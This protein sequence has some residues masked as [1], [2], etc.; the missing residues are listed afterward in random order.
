MK[1]KIKGLIYFFT[2]AGILI[3]GTLIVF[4][5]QSE[6]IAIRLSDYITSRFGQER[7]L[8]IEVGNIGGS[9]LR[10]IRLEDLCISYTG[11]EAPRVLLSAAEVYGKF[12]LASILIGKVTFDSIGVKSARLILPRRSD[13]SFIL[14]TG[15]AP[16]QPGGKRSRLEIKK[17]ALA[18]VSVVVEGGEPKVFTDVD[19]V[20]SYVQDAG[21]ST[22]NLEC[23]SF[24][25]GKAAQIDRITGTARITDR[26]I[27]ITDAVVQSPGSR[28][29]FSGSIGIDDND[30]LRVEAI[31]DSLDIG[32]AALFYRQGQKSDMGSIAGHIDAQGRY[33]DLS[34][35]L[36]LEGAA[37]DW[38]FEDLLA[39]AWYGGKEIRIN[40]LT[41]VL[42]KTPVD[43]SGE[44]TFSAPPEYEGVIAFANLDL[45]EFIRDSS[46]DYSSD[47]SGSVRFRGEGVDAEHFALETWPRLASGRYL[48]W[49]FDSVEGKVSLDAESVT[50]DGVRAGIGEARLKTD[51]A[52]GFDGELDLGFVLSCPDLGDIASYHKLEDLVGSITGTGRVVHKDGVFG[53]LLLSTGKQIE[54]GGTV[55]DSLVLDLDLTRAESG[56]RG[57]SQIFASSLDIH[58]FKATEFIGDVSVEDSRIAIERAVFIRENEDLLGAVGVVDLVDGGFDLGV[59]NL[60]VELGGF[61][62]ENADTILASYRQD[63][64]SVGDF[65]ISSGMGRVSIFNSSYVKGKYTVESRLDDFDL[66]LLE[67]VVRAEIP[68]G[69]L[70]LDLKASGTSDS[71]AFEVDFGV[72]DGEFRSVPFETLSGALSYNGRALSI[73]RISLAQNGGN[74]IVEGMVPMNLAPSR[75][76]ELAKAGRAYD[77]ID[78]LGQVTIQATDIDISLIET[79]LPPLAKLKGY[80]DLSMEISGSKSNPLVVSTGRL[81][82]AN[83]H[84]TR[85]GEISWNLNLKDSLLTISEFTF[86]DGR[87]TGSISGQVPIAISI[88]PFRSQLLKRPI[89]VAVSVEGGDVGLMCSLFPQLR[90]CSGRYDVDLGITGTVDDPRFRGR[91]SLSRARLR[92]A[93]VAQDVRDLFIDV[94]LEGKRFEITRL[95][96]EEGAVTGIGFLR[97]EGTRIVEW[98]IDLAFKDYA[99]TEFEDFYARIEGNLTI[100]TE[101]FESG[102]PIPRIEGSL[103]VKEGEYFYSLI[104]GGG[105]GEIIA[106]SASPG[107]IMNVAIEVP[108]DFWIRGDDIEAELQGDLSVKRGKEGL[109]V[110]GSLRTLRGRFYV[111]H[112]SFRI[113]RGE[114]RFSDVTSLKNAYIDLEAESRVL[115]EKITLLAKGYIDRLDISA[116]SESG[117]SET[118]IFEALTLRRGTPSDEAEQKGFFSSEFIRSWGL[119]LVNRF[120]NDVAR[121][122]NLDQFG[123][124]VGDLGEGDALATTR[125]IFGKYVSDKVYLEYTQAL[126]SLYGDRTRFT[127]RGLSFPER[128]LSVEY[129]L[130]N[131]FSIEGETGTVGGLGY[132]DVD[133]KFT[134]GY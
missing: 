98:D 67:D 48:E 124:E 40:R 94:E 46:E 62:W 132:F 113:T 26:V 36:D 70:G 102:K 134:F 30:S 35:R 23:C 7:N 115:D 120:G 77:I 54:Y 110:L 116:T 111:Y 47:L 81:R 45:S 4:R 39:D 123:V 109:L 112:N 104:G 105:E 126:G 73:G 128:Q 106:P 13:G 91:I 131:R 75:V 59:E 78:D 125:L 103:K 101:I 92:L 56:L 90:V 122:L 71:L 5:T 127:Q 79:L 1:R 31:I 53:V 51:G 8:S 97:L 57:R 76:S 20:G 74:V 88:L 61:I 58:G 19:M 83:Y 49:G 18:E 68:T 86:G 11:G 85:I 133:L 130:S 17:I 28:L 84:V 38:V 100:S 9:L 50:L 22:V 21:G 15:D 118:Q 69:L 87:E 42:N 99:V 24:S 72:A 37:G 121:E 14:P 34:L 65:E 10:D 27:E 60:F 117:W 3:I 80:A 63:S 16:S 93:A 52:I 108:N 44:Y 96:A 64:L 32:E 119:A 43:V 82:E 95:S 55:I 29:A 114:F 2:V 107:W 25:Y 129:R 89:D 33:S 41:S 6:K 66:D 12:N